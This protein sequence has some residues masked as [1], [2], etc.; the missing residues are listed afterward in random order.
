MSSGSPRLL[1]IFT[2]ATALVVG[3]IA[4]LFTDNWIFLP[5][6]LGIH[7]IGTAAVLMAI[8]PRL[9]DEDKPDPVTEARLEEERAA[10]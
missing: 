10:R 1:V 2:A 6:A 7:A 5:L 4:A 8:V 3:L 9:K